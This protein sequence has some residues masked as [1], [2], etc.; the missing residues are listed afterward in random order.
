MTEHPCECK[1]APTIL[2]LAVIFAFTSR[3]IYHGKYEHSESMFAFTGTLSL[4]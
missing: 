1:Y 2:T 4:M 3:I